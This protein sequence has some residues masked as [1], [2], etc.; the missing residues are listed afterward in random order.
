[1]L[2]KC[3]TFGVAWVMCLCPAQLYA[4]HYLT[5]ESTPAVADG[6]TVYRFY[7]NMTDETDRM[8]AIY[9]NDES[10]LLVY[11]PEGAFNS[12][13]NPSWNASGIS[14][15][16]LPLFPEMANDTYATIG[17]TGPASTSG[18]PNAADPSIVEDNNQPI[19]PFFLTQGATA[20]ES[21]TLTGAS[22]YILNTAANGLP[23]DDLRVLIL[24][25]TTSGSISGT[26]NYQVFPLGVGANDIL[27]SVD[28][29]G[30]GNFGEGASVAGCTDANACNYDSQAAED[31]GSCT[32]CDCLIDPSAYYTLTIE[33]TPAVQAGLTRHMFYI[34]LVNP[35]DKFSAVFGNVDNPIYVNVPSGAYNSALNATWNASGINPAFLGAFPEMADDTYATIGLTG[36]ASTSGI[37][38]ASD[39][40][41]AQDPDQPITPFFL[42][43]G[44][45]SLAVDMLIGSSW[46]VLS[47]NGNAN[48][49]DDQRVLIMQV[50]TPGEV[51][52]Q[53]NVQVFPNGI[54]A[55]QTTRTYSFDGNGLYF[56]EGVGNACG[57]TDPAALNFDPSADYDDGSCQLTVAGCTDSSACNYDPTASADDGS[58]LALDCEGVCGG[59]ASLDACGV[60]NGPGEI[61]ACGCADIPAGDC[62]CD[63]NQLDALGV[64]GGA[65]AADA[66][67]DGI[68]DDVDDCIGAYDTC[69]VCNGPGEIYACG[70]SDIPAGDCDCDGNQLD[71]LGVCGGACAADADS[72]GI[73]DDVDDCIGA[74][75]TCGVC[76]GPGEIYACGCSDIP[77]GDCDCD[78]NQLDALGVCGGACAADADSDGIC[79][80]V[81][82]CI[83]DALLCCNDFN[84]NGICDNEDVPGCT[85]GNA[86]NYDENATMDNSTCEFPCAGDLSGDGIVQLTDLLDFLITYGS[87]CE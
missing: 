33:S 2:A 40:A 6:L 76:N 56:P 5:V 28:F 87:V 80:D 47:D 12:A 35:D 60:C 15:A 51:S 7:V 69:G 75:D 50:T 31:D 36:P 13:F 71:A 21:T 54:G 73:C 37:A 38:N 26:M 42:E 22:W 67:S 72:D 83:G 11:T 39:P 3:L 25:V 52:G 74:Y 79:D 55:N 19:T 4:Q 46:F 65:C 14:P 59:D 9:G 78:G 84:G 34:D 20:L 62:D 18:I 81:D 45:T 85:Y 17:L 68:C 57:C 77:A 53:L 30:P 16:F 24:Q 43:D 10:P 58:C 66:D 44:A 63:G 49:D 70:C 41:L 64:C 27:Y 29:D 8:S 23:D 86:T 32:F 48:P 1:M 61:Y 82:D